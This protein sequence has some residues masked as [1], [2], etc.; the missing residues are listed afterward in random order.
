VGPA[1]A[2]AQGVHHPDRHATAVTTTVLATEFDIEP[3]FV[4]SVVLI[5]TLASIVTVTLFLTLLA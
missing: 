1:G 3:G 5:T 4:T 2:D